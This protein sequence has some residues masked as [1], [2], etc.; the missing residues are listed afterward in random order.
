MKGLNTFKRI[1]SIVLVSFMFTLNVFAEETYNASYRI[2][3]DEE[4]GVTVEE[5][6][7]E[8][9]IDNSE[10]E[11][12]VIKKSGDDETIIYT[13]PLGEYED[14][15]WSF[16][17]FSE[18]QF[19]V[20]F[21]CEVPEDE[22]IYIVPLNAS[23]QDTIV[24][25]TQHNISLLSVDTDS[26]GTKYSIK[27]AIIKNS[28]NVIVHDCP[29]NG[30]LESVT[31]VKHTN[32]TVPAK[33]FAAL[34]DDGRLENMKVVDVSGGEAAETEIECDINLLFGTITE[35]HY[36]K[37]M[38]WDGL[39]TLRPLMAP[40]DTSIVTTDYV[41]NNTIQAIAQEDEYTFTVPEDGYYNIEFGGNDSISAFLFHNDTTESSIVTSTFGQTMSCSL[42]ADEIYVLK[43]TA[44]E[45]GVY[46]FSIKQTEIPE[47]NV[48]SV[49]INK[50]GGY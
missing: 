29:S 21:D 42:S 12:Q 30:Q 48:L 4:Q 23:D 14:G 3:I 6:T 40:Y 22:A 34:Y 5:S 50:V 27:Q 43:V 8:G 25:S 38:V 46:S 26:G 7:L 39:D 17:D 49:G 44:T 13:G 32:E 45:T 28:D 10:L 33:V 36:V 47:S 35:N 19:L 20:L 15:M 37:I 2:D 1:I 18:I 41:Y 24:D 9:D 16:T 31:L 11:V